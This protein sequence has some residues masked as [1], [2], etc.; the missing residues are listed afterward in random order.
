MGRSF[1]AKVVFFSAA[2]IVGAPLTA[3]LAATNAACKQEYA[4]KH[5]AGQTAGLRKADHVKACLARQK[6]AADPEPSG[7]DTDTD[8]AKKTENP[9]ADLIGVPLN[10]YSTFNYGGEGR[11][12]CLKFSR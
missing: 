1:G 3:A 2:A 6:T 10:N 12:T 8:L 5:A 11:S 7:G 4:A 9:I